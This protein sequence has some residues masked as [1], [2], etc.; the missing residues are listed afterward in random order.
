MSNARLIESLLDLYRAESKLLSR[1]VNTF[2]RLKLESSENMILLLQF[3][4]Y[5]T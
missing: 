3:Q 2:K 1:A 4:S 5:K